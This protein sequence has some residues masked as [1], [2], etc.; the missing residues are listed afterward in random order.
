MTTRTHQARGRARWLT[1][2]VA[3]LAAL[4]LGAGPAGAVL[5]TGPSTEHTSAGTGSVG[6]RELVAMSSDGSREVFVGRS[7][8]DQGIWLRDR[9]SGDSYRITTE[10]DVNPDISADGTTVAFARYGTNRSVYTVDVTDPSSPG[11]EQQV[12]VNSDEEPADGLSDF[13]SLD[14]DGSVVAFHSTATNLDPDTPLPS[15]GG[16]TKVYRRDLVAGTTAMVSVDND[17]NA[18]PGNSIKPD[19]SADGSLVA[20]ASE[21]DLSAAATPAAEE[22]E[23]TTVVQIFV[24]DTTGGTTTMAST[25]SAGVPGD[26]AAA[27]LYGPTIS[28]DGNV[29]GFESLAT[30]LVPGDTNGTTDA[31]RHD[32]SSGVTTRVSERTTFD[33]FGAFHA[34]TPDRVLD[35]RDTSDPLGPG[36]TITIDIAGVG[37]VPADA[38]GVALNLT[39]TEPTSW[40]WLTIWPADEPMPT[41]S[42]LNFL[43]GETVANAATLKLADN[44]KISINNPFGDS[45]VIVDVAGWY[46]DAQ[47]SS[48]GGFVGMAP[49]R[50]LDTRVSGTP[51]APDSTIDVPLAGTLG[52]PADATA[53][54][55]SVT[56]TEPTSW[57]WLTAWPTGDTQPLASNLNFLAGQTVANSVVVGVGD[58]GMVS[59]Y[60]AIGTT[61]V[62]VDVMGWFDASLPNGGFTPVT[63]TRILD[64]RS[65]APVTSAAPY[66]LEVVGSGPVPAMGVTTVALNV[67]VTE[68]STWGWLTVFPTGAPKPLSSNLNFLGGETVAVQVLAQVGAGGKVSLA[69]DPYVAAHLVVD[70]VGWYSGVQVAEGGRGAVVSGDGLHTGFES[71]A[72][73]MTAGDLNGV[74]DVFV[75]DHAT[76]ITE[77]ASVVDETLGGTEA[78]GTRIDGNTGEVVPQNN[79]I[80]AAINGDGQIIAFTSN[81]NLTNDRTESEETPG[82]ISTEPAIFTR[83][84]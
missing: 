82:E 27:E 59:L 29:V 12:S 20:F 17:G 45:H 74:F 80:D 22:E 57:G 53:V 54:A 24:R 14:A 55:L 52:V 26:A 62:V 56:A 41:V 11:P 16:P 43:A 33:E 49:A 39:V 46:D 1:A 77:R 69:V 38:A 67:T 23:P 76:G 15:S 61:E 6:G 25:D 2:T 73:T 70:V 51:M 9:S 35:T 32:M 13:P 58:G 48:G 63:P 83:T 30:N 71:V 47:L 21:S 64:T 68:P 42:T 60:N 44:G 84:R 37:D 7:S 79:G 40:G 5:P 8:V 65:G 31:F 3:G 50:A 72:T 34:V 18:Q 19:L 75:R 4:A 10:N 28:A 36:E 81:G 66:E 78:T